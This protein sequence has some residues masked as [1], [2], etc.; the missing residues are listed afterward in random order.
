MSKYIFQVAAS[1]FCC[2]STQLGSLYPS[3]QSPS[4][5]ANPLQTWRSSWWLLSERHFE[6]QKIPDDMFVWSVNVVDAED[7]NSSRASCSTKYGVMWVPEKREKV[8]YTIFPKKLCFKI[9]I[10]VP[11]HWPRGQ[12]SASSAGPRPCLAHWAVVVWA[13]PVPAPDTVVTGPGARSPGLSGKPLR[14]WG[15]GG[16]ATGDFLLP[17]LLLLPAQRSTGRQ[18]RVRT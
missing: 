12:Y 18:I 2:W 3:L 9:H 13:L 6:A 4:C 11:A 8:W 15:T 5:T 7:M 10:A 16:E 17:M 1:W 14:C